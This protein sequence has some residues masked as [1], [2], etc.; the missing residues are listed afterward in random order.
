MDIQYYKFFYHRKIII[1]LR[2]LKNVCLVNVILLV[3]SIQNVT[4]LRVSVNADPVLLVVDAIVAL[5]RM[6]K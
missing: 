5:I 1:N 3:H 6:Q 4:K 2:D